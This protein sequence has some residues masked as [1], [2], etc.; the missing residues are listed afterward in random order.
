M[1]R[2]LPVWSGQTQRCGCHR[3]SPGRRSGT[4]ARGLE[5]QRSASHRGRA[6]EGGPADWHGIATTSRR[7]LR[8]S[9]DAHR[10]VLPPLPA[11]RD[12]DIPMP[13]A[14]PTPDREECG[15]QL[16]APF[17]DARAN[18]TLK[19]PRLRVLRSR[20]EIDRKEPP[21]QVLRDPKPIP[22]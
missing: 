20:V 12:R 17:Y 15:Q 16:R 9:A 3:A 6:H 5:G 11:Q 8:P 21:C 19:R 1:A 4:A 7:G 22:C 2:R 14:T 18:V 10:A 13:A